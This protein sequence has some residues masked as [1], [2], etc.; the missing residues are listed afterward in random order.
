MTLPINERL[1]IY[2]NVAIIR[3]MEQHREKDGMDVAIDFFFG[4]IVGVLA[5]SGVYFVLK[6]MIQFGSGYAYWIFL[7]AGIAILGSLT[8]LFRNRVRKKPKTGSLLAPTGECIA[9]RTQVL[10]WIIFVLGCVSLVGLG[11]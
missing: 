9:I 10:L 2:G 1:N 8:A 7:F 6:Q 3:R 5:G 11:L 4:A